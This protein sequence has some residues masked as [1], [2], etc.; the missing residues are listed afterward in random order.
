MQTMT[1]PHSDLLFTYPHWTG[2]VRQLYKDYVH[3]A[4]R[5]SEQYGI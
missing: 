2:S 3:D 5:L 1:F 4:K